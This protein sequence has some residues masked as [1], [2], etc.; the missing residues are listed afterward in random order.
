MITR[1]TLSPQIKFEVEKDK[2]KC[3]TAKKYGI[4]LNQFDMIVFIDSS[5]ESPTMK[6]LSKRCI[7]STAAITGLIDRLEKLGIVI[8]KHSAE[9]R[10]KVLV[11]LSDTGLEIVGNY[12][13]SLKKLSKSLKELEPQTA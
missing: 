12:T 11:H 2:L 13:D 7:V 5:S 3:I 9:D 10:R 4:S 8:R 6:D 1:S